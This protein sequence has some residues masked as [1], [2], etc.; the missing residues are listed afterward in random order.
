MNKPK[1]LKTV[2]IFSIILG[3]ALFVYALIETILLIDEIISYPEITSYLSS[4]MFFGTAFLGLGIAVLTKV[5]GIAEFV[6]MIILL[7]FYLIFSLTSISFLELMADVELAGLAFFGMLH[8]VAIPIAFSIVYI[9]KFAK[10]LKKQKFE[11]T[12]I[13]VEPETSSLDAFLAEE[14]KQAEAYELGMKYY[15]E[16][17]YEKAVKAFQLILDYKDSRHKIVEIKE[18]ILEIEKENLLNNK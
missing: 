13:S 4:L 18:I 9:I 11:T 2:A 16:K 7:G 3:A 5:K 10:G 1:S 14:R 17:N 6:L 12:I 8:V 15:E